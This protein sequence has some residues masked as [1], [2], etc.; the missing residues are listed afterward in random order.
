MGEAHLIA[1]V[2]GGPFEIALRH[3]DAGYD[4]F[5]VRVDF[6][7]R[8]RR[9]SSVFVV[10]VVLAFFRDFRRGAGTSPSVPTL[11]FNTHALELYPIEA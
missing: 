8:R 9:P 6:R 10:V 3:F 1:A 7:P 11:R 4:R 2:D 5:H